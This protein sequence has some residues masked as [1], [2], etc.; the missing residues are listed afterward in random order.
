M[1]VLITLSRTNTESLIEVY[2]PELFDQCIAF[3]GW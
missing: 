2:I 1:S 3:N